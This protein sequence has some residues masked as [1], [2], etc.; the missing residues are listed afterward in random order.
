MILCYVTGVG[1]TTP[2]TNFFL[3]ET[4][5]ALWLA[6][7]I[8][9]ASVANATHDDTL[10][11][12]L[13]ASSQLL[14]QMAKDRDTEGLLPYIGTENVARDLL[15]ITETAGQEK[16]LYWGVSYANDICVFSCSL[17]C[18][19]L[20]YGTVLGATFAT[21]FPVRCAECP[22]ICYA[23]H[24]PS[25]RIAL[26]AW[27][28]TVS[29]TWRPGTRVRSNMSTSAISE[30]NHTLQPQAI[31]AQGWKTPTRRF[32]SSSIV[33]LQPALLN[34]PSTPTPPPRSKLTSRAYTTLSP[35]PPFQST[36]VL[37]STVSLTITY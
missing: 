4:E 2:R 1:V 24:H 22:Y 11:P 6:N 31:N 23:H 10:L 28:S 19:R 15:R 37:P 32:K 29:R 34:A 13:W 26:I 7:P 18:L 21:M 5:H 30:T 8:N 33:V 25:F 3:T 16:L 36:T 17:T 27:L 35:R 20:R 12:K 9:Y 14:G